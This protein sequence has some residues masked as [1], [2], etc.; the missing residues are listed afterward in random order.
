MSCPP[1]DQAPSVLPRVSVLIPTWDGLDDLLI[2][3]PQNAAGGSNAG[4]S[5]LFFGSTV[6]S[7]GSFDL[8]T[9][10]ASFVGENVSS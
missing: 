1:S 7:G 6:S 2:G 3:A 8:S 10:D 9:A 5:Y 4:K